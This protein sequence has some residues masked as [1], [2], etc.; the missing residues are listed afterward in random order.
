MKGI[1][2]AICGDII[3][4]TREFNSIKSKNFD[5]I[6]KHSTFTDDTVLTLCL[7]SWLIKDQSF[8]K[9]VLINE[10]KL[11]CSKYNRAGYG[12]RFKSWINSD[13]TQPYNS[14]GNG[15]AMRVS[16]VA[17]VGNSL[18]EVETLAKISA[19]VTHNHPEG[20]KGAVA[21]AGSIYLAREGKDKDYIKKY[22]ETNFKYNLSRKLDEI[23][24]EYSFEVSCQKSV[25][26][27]IICFLESNDYED[28][29]RNAISLGGDADTQSAIS[30]SIASA[31]YD[32]PEVIFS[33][34]LDKLDKPLL[35]IF[36]EFN[37][38]YL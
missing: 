33:N 38:K 17:W 24:P 14:W 20:I 32:V 2:G 19:E 27:S 5:L 36:N 8:S 15:S 18:N 12:H 25:P 10:I 28:T 23:R 37:E 13:E 9:K 35:N 29:I 11:I 26:E 30:G 1:V 3:G 22:V 7:A 4:S 31:Y 16:P 34:C 6:P 21:I